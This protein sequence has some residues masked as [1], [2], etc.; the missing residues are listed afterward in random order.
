MSD[1]AFDE[2]EFVVAWCSG[3]GR[4]VLTYIPADDP[5]EERRHCVHCDVALGAELRAA[6]GSELTAA[7]YAVVEP[8]GCGNP[9]CGGGQCA[10]K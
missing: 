10:R 8:Q 5:D 6:P 3:C 9:N 1:A 4:E 7:G 2:S